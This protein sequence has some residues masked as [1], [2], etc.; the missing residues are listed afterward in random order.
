M[1][2]A[3]VLPHAVYRR[4]SGVSA[5]PEGTR[6]RALEWALYFAVDGTQTTAELGRRLRADDAE[7]DRAFV[8][9]LSLGLIEEQE[10]NASEYVRAL[11][12]SGDSDEKSMRDFLIGAVAPAEPEAPPAPPKPPLRPAFGFKPLPRPQIETKEKTPMPGSRKLSLRAL[13]AL[14]ERQAGNRDA[15]QLDVY[16][17]F[18]RVDTQLL[19]R[20]GIETLRFTEDRFVSDPELERAIVRSVKKT[21]GFDCPENLWIEVA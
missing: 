14:I 6:L 17:V 4:S 21:L 7:R 18:V 19:K 20:N 9:L 11:A 10:L 8:K 3:V 1:S 16:R 15:G 2:A 12:A 13:M 5:L